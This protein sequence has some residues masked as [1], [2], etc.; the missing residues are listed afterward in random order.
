MPNITQAKAGSQPI[1][2]PNAASHREL[3]D[4]LAY[5][6]VQRRKLVSIRSK[7]NLDIAE[8]DRETASLTDAHIAATARE[9]AKVPKR[10]K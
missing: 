8:I 1:A 10:P 3:A 5:R 2:D 7:I 9:M 6:A 4:R